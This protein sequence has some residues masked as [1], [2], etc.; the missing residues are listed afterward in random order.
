M[1]TAVGTNRYLHR[2][3][4]GPTAMLKILAGTLPLPA[5]PGRVFFIISILIQ[6]PG[7]EDDGRLKLPGIDMI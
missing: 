1:F 4:Q 3:N 2:L 7:I 6:S 5:D